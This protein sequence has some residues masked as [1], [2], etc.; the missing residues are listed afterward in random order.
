[1]HF[2]G[3]LDNFGRFRTTLL[4]FSK[5]PTKLWYRH[6]R[7][8][9]V[10]PF[11]DMLQYKASSDWSSQ[12][13]ELMDKV[14]CIW[15]DRFNEKFNHHNWVTD[16]KG[17]WMFKALSIKQWSVAL[18]NKWGQDVWLTSASS[19]SAASSEKHSRMP[20]SNSFGVRQLFVRLWNRWNVLW[21][22]ANH[23]G[24][25]NGNGRYTHLL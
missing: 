14:I 3:H 24:N 15:P 2:W 8:N 7:W 20:Y 21:K 5:V 16:K 10:V 23:R 6:D 25:C 12:M 9:H 17:P 4:L 13:T 1:M 11:D 18:S 19:P 22:N